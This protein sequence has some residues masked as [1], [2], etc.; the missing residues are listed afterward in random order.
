MENTEITEQN[1][2]KFCDWFFAPDDLKVLI[3][4]PGSGGA[5]KTLIR[6]KDKKAFVD[7]VLKYNGTMNLYTVVNKVDDS[8]IDK[9][10]YQTVK[11]DE[12]TKY[13]TLY[14]DIDPKRK[15]Q[16]AGKQFAADDEE[17]R[18]AYQTANNIYDFLKENDFPEPLFCFTGNG[19]SL[20]YVIDLN[21]EPAVVRREIIEPII[22]ILSAKYTTAK[23]GINEGN[24]AI[25][26]DSSIV[27][28][29]RLRRV[30]GSLNVKGYMS[31]ET[32][33]KY[34]ERIHRYCTVEYLPDERKAVPLEVLQSFID[35]F[36]DLLTQAENEQRSPRERRSY[37]PPVPI[38]K[39]VTEGGR[40]KA[41]VKLAGYLR[42]ICAMEEAQILDVLKKYNR[43][44]M[45]PPK[46]DKELAHIAKTICKY[47]KTDNLQATLSVTINET[48]ITE[49]VAKECQDE[50]VYNIELDKWMVWTGHYWEIDISNEVMRRIQRVIRD[51]V[52]KYTSLALNP[53]LTEGQLNMIRGTGKKKGIIGTLQSFDTWNHWVPI[54]KRLAVTPG[55]YIH[56]EQTNGYKHCINCK[57]GV[58]DLSNR[59]LTEHDKCR[60]MYFTYMFNAEYDP[61]ATC[62]TFDAFLN[63][64]MLGNK[65]MVRFMLKMGG[66][67]LD[68][69][70]VFEKFFVLRGAGGNGKSVWGESLL[71]I[72][73]DYGINTSYDTWINNNSKN[74]GL[75]RLPGKRFILCS[76]VPPNATLNATIVKN[77]V[78]GDA[79]TA[80]EKFQRPFDFIPQGKLMFLVNHIPNVTD[81]S[82]A[83]TRRM[84]IV[85][86][87][88]VPTEDKRDPHLKAKIFAEAS[89]VLNRLLE[90][91]YMLQEEGFKNLPPE[92]VDECREFTFEVD[93]LSAFLDSEFIKNDKARVSYK[94]IRER[95]DNW[96][97][98]KNEKEGRSTRIIT[99]AFREKGFKKVH[100]NDGEYIVGLQLRQDSEAAMKIADYAEMQEQFKK[101]MAANQKGGA[102]VGV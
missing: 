74:W 8:N 42:G 9:A 68:G 61:K 30:A 79:V 37:A 49:A 94:D 18:A 69:D 27:N 15:V 88:Y 4:I 67:C 47:D 53:D 39:L 57:N 71:H 81:Y 50:L 97:M 5:S 78:S 3:G 6:T 82:N 41:L 70:Q 2:N 62:P 44:H 72:F 76:E 101:E 56:N 26:I 16:V 40:H 34:P 21:L 77:F 35:N 10:A 83:I 20:D 19:Y 36:R 31:E 13:R 66:Y 65:E 63:E 1:I 75:G 22:A 85:P 11:N 87:D 96:A 73:G 99:K 95:Y 90:G 89:G 64:I 91:Y 24:A 55:M 52:L 43:D 32:L 59:T 58:L 92:I 17:Q 100:S 48:Y 45:I 80:E 54:A 23:T 86:F 14:I 102:G 33:E 84:I 29:A 28:E 46:S 51:E 60:H 93:W 38:P 98:L 12:I 7:A 25:E